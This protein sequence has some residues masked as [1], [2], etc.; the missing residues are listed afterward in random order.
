MKR[1]VKVYGIAKHKTVPDMSSASQAL[2][3]RNRLLHNIY[4]Y[5][6]VGIELYNREE[7]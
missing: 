6:P 4:K 1:Y 5:L 2:Q 7:Y 3:E